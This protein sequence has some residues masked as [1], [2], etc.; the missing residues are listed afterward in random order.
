MRSPYAITDGKATVT[1]AP[2]WGVE[3]SPEWLAGA[4]YRVS[5]AG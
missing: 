2:G 4:E 1:E 3:I 5:E